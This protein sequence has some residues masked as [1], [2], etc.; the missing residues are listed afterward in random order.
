M[1]GSIVWY[2][3]RRPVGAPLTWGEAMVG[4]TY[5]FFILFWAYGVVPHL[6]LTWADN[7]L[8]WRPDKLF[9][10]PRTKTA[11]CE[12]EWGTSKGCLKW[13]LP[14]TITWQTVRDIIVVVIYNVIIGI[15]VAMFLKWQARGKTKAVEVAKSEYGRPLVKSGA[16]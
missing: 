7:E 15:N 8:K 11:A 13:P 1:I 9:L 2:Q 3:K 5:I 16:N 10:L 4:A 14:I 6:F 12:W